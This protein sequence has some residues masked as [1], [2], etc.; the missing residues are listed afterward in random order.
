MD[1]MHNLYL[2]IAKHHLKRLWIATGLLGDSEFVSIQDRIDNITPPD[3]GRIPCKIQS[4]FSSFTAEQ[5]KNWIF[6]LLP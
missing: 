5:F 1:A 4:G 6:L 2:G 3:L